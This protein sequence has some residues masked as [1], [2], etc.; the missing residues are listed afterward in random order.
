MYPMAVA[1]ITA[2]AVTCMAAYRIAQLFARP[3]I[4]L[5]FDPDFSVEA[6]DMDMIIKLIDEG[7]KIRAIKNQSS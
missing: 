4:K 2:T 1:L 5:K 6:D 7:K 3:R